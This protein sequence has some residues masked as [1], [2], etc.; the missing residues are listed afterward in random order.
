MALEMAMLEIDSRQPV[1]GAR[2]AHLDFTRLREVRLILPARVDLPGEHE[3]MWRFPDEHGA[4]VAFGAVGLL[5]VAAPAGTR[6]DDG[7]LHRRLPDVMAA[8]PPAVVLRGKHL[9]R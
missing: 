9:E 1:A 3:A 8:R 6:F 2:E 7:L 4:P 5:G